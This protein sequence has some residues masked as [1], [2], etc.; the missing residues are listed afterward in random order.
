MREWGKVGRDCRLKELDEKVGSKT[1]TRQ[2]CDK[3]SESMW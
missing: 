1:V 3:R 2:E